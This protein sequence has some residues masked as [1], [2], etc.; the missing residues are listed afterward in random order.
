[1]KTLL[2]LAIVAFVF[3]IPSLTENEFELH[4]LILT[5]IYLLLAHGLNL[6]MGYTG[7]LSKA[8]AAFWGIGAYASALLMMRVGLN[9]WLALP[10][11]GLFVALVAIGVGIPALNLRGIYFA[12][13]T[14]GFA[15]VARMVMIN[16]ISLTQGPMGLV[17]IPPP[18]GIHLFGLVDVEFVSVRSFYYLTASFA[19]AGTAVMAVIVNS[20]LGRAFIA[21]REDEDLAETMG[22]HTKKYKILSF[23][24]SG[25][26]A[27]VAGSLYAHY[28]QFLEPINFIL[29]EA[30][31]ILIMVISGG[32]GALYGPVLGAI[33]FTQLPERLT[34]LPGVLSVPKESWAVFYGLLLMVVI[35]FMPRGMWGGLEALWSWV[36]R[37]RR[38][39]STLE[40]ESES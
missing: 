37:G 28:I 33:V 3:L 40:A 30:I 24:I 20:R 16:W 22:L 26:Y 15:E 32:S 8:Q 19:V 36:T 11:A 7:Q 2:G 25:F 27:G 35:L 31:Y 6:I 13:A 5:A 14:I 12:I 1:M 34:E 21:I 39:P 4:L 10:A 17:G 18:S 29:I 23:A 38:R 9:F